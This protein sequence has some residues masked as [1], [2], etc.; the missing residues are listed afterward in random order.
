MSDN[1]VPGGDRVLASLY[2]AIT[3]DGR[4]FGVTLLVGGSWLT[5][6]AINGRAWWNQLAEAVRQSARGGGLDGTLRQL[7]QQLYPAEIEVEA[8][9]APPG[10]AAQVGGYIHL[11]DASL[12]FPGADAGMPTPGSFVRVRLDEVQAWML[13]NLGPADYVPPPPIV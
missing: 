7:G 4:E 1:G 13:G 11:R 3:T 9:L 12:R 10:D 5:G 2:E 8:G 6:M